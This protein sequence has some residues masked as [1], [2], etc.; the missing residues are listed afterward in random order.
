[1]KTSKVEYIGSLRTKC[2]HYRSGTEII[3]DAPIDNNGRGEAFSPTDLVATAY[4]SCMMTIIGIY[5]N[6]HGLNFKN[7][8]AEIT[9]V[10]SAAPRRISEIVIDLDLSGN[11]WD[12]DE[13]ERVLRA[14]K[15][16]PVAKSVHENIVITF[17]IV[18]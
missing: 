4:A 11:G 18:L 2:T 9:K 7:G 17:D 5:C 10:M 13:K 3:T 14:G 6:E 1:M 16:C 8:V 15:A 12:E